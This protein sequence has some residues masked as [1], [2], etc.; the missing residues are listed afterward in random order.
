MDKVRTVLMQ[1]RSRAEGPFFEAF[2][3][4]AFT[5]RA[6]E[7]SPGSRGLDANKVSPGL[8]QRTAL[9]ALV[10]SCPPPFPL[11]RS[12]AAA[13]VSSTHV[14]PRA[15]HAGNWAGVAV[16]SRMAATMDAFSDPVTSM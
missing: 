12:P 2:R 3:R 6:I 14:P 9:V 10:L 13:A 4:G 11:L 7:L 1:R 15:S 8:G 16:P 5:A